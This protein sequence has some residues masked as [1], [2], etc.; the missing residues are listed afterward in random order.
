MLV[1]LTQQTG[2][3]SALEPKILDNRLLEAMQHFA[4]EILIRFVKT[5][6]CNLESDDLQRRKDF[7]TVV[8]QQLGLGELQRAEHCKLD[9]TV[10][11]VIIAWKSSIAGAVT[12]ICQ[13]QV[14]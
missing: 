9:G 7:Q 1:K 2:L 12:C 13:I 10:A 8:S 14:T 5:K 4:I 6:A 11:S 3:G